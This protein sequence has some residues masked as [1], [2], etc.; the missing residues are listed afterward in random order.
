M[1]SAQWSVISNATGHWQLAT[2]FMD[3]LYSSLMDL[4][5]LFFLSWIVLIV[6]ACLVTFRQDIRSNPLPRPGTPIKSGE[7]SFQAHTS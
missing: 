7:K 6:V 1:V 2:S 5:Q 3:L 4:S